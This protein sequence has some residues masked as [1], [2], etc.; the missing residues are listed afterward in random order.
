MGL[1]IKRPGR[2]TDYHRYRSTELKDQPA[3][4]VLTV[5]TAFFIEE[6]ECCDR[7]FVGGYQIEQRVKLAALCVSHWTF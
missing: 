6:T 3:V 1:Q 7:L 5:L 4:S 2:E